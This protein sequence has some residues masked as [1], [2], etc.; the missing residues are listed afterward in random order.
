MD[1]SKS[2]AW[3]HPRIER[4]FWICPHCKTN[5]AERIES[6]D[7]SEGLPDY[8]ATTCLQCGAA[9]TF[10][11]RWSMPAIYS[12]QLVAAGTPWFLPQP[13]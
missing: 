5:M 11:L 10:H 1:E 12:V 9:L 4:A 3:D 13:R 2:F 6:A 8:A 7:T